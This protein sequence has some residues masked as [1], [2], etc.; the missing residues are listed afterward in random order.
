MIQCRLQEPKTFQEFRTE[1]PDLYDGLQIPDPVQASIAEWYDS[2]RVC[3]DELFGRFFR[4]VLSRDFT[5]FEQLQ[6]ITP[7]QG[8]KPG[9]TKYDWLVQSYKERQRFLQTQAQKQG[10]GS[11]AKDDD[12]T[13][14]TSDTTSEQVQ[15][16]RTQQTTTI[17]DDSRTSS[18]VKTG[19][20]GTTTNGTRT[21]N[22]GVTR[23]DEGGTITSYTGDNVTVSEGNSETGA[24]S[25]Q[26]VN[27]MSI[28]YPNFTQ[29]PEGGDPDMVGW[30]VPKMDWTAPSSQAQDRSKSDTTTTTTETPRVRTT[31]KGDGGEDY[32][33]TIGTVTTRETVQSALNETD[34]T[35]E[36]YDGDRR[37]TT[38]G[39][40]G[41]TTTGQRAGNAHRVVE[42]DTT[43]QNTETEDGRTL[44]R[45]IYSGRD[46]SLSQ[47]LQEAKRYII[48]TDAFQ[49]LIDRLEVCFLGVYD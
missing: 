12:I 41:K 48:S 44:E 23:T 29:E 42:S 26:K 7:G 34:S 39:Q 30:H 5:R 17:T 35:T 18:G 27:P 43:T 2:R 38:T 20:S 47:L 3:D 19:E 40:D 16:A 21:E 45:E 4:R 10:T 49:W 46:A 36:S 9:A 8:F 6:R 37:T 14:I 22:T 24:R 33:N 15:G 13:D 11:V 31:V 1:N 28:S 25:V 32:T